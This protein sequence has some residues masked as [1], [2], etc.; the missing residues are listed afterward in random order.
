MILVYN[1]QKLHGIQAAAL[2]LVE[3]QEV[4]AGKHLLTY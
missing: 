1:D 3:E 4:A 2:Q